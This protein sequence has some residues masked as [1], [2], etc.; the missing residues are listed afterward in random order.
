MNC[1]CKC[2]LFFV[3]YPKLVGK[4]P[5]HNIDFNFLLKAIIGNYTFHS[6]GEILDSNLLSLFF[7]LISHIVSFVIF[8]IKEKEYK[9]ID[10]NTLTKAPYERVILLQ[11]VILFGSFL[12]FRYQNGTTRLFII[13]ISIKILLDLRAHIKDKIQK[14]KILIS[15]DPHRASHKKVPISKLSS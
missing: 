15:C 8:F 3:F 6:F 7:L 12:I 5:N 4:N 2:F 14:N 11:V 10:K 13:L 1:I 9:I